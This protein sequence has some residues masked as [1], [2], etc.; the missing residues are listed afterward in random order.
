MPDSVR[1]SSIADLPAQTASAPATDAEA[2]GRFFNP[3]NAFNV[4]LPAVP[5]RAFTDE[6][7]KALDPQTP[8]GMTHCDAS[9]VMEC[10]FP[11]TAPLVLASYARVRA[12]E[13]LE[14]DVR[15]TGIIY[16]VMQGVGVAEIGNERINWSEGDVFIAPGG[17]PQTLAA[18]SDDAVLWVASNQPQLMHEHSQP[19]A[20]GDAP[21]PVVHYTAAEIQKQID[22]LYDIGKDA[23]VPGTALI[24]SSDAQESS[25]NVMPTL[26]LA[27]NT[28]DP[29]VVQRPHRHNSVAVSLVVKGENCYS[30]VDG[31]KKAWGPWAT[32]I[33]PPVSVHSHHNEGDE[34]AFFLIVQDGGF[35]YHARAMGFEFVDD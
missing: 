15:A 2:R 3:G 26:T 35:Y 13:R 32:T 34:R 33:T 4:I 5:D 22:F 14:M 29:G 17:V 27:M 6:P 23:E 24:F 8:T 16:Y 20:P 1:P 9:D 19:P 18:G 31:R 28:L 12:G 10:P 7:I 21:T 25:R 30:K 11:A